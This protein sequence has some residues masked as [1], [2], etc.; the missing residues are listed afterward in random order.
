MNA[1]TSP[2]Q[3]SAAIAPLI[4]VIIPTFNSSKTLEN[5]LKSI[6]NQTYK[7]TELII[8]DAFSKDNTQQIAE[9]FKT[10]VFLLVA[11]R[12]TARNFGAKQAMGRFLFFV[13]SDMELAT[14]VIEEC[15][16]I[17]AKKNVDAAIIPEETVGTSFLAKC[18]K[19]EKR[20]RWREVF[21]EAPRFLKKEVFEF[22][23]GYNEDL[24]IGEDFELAQRLRN[25]GFSTERCKAIIKHH[26]EN[27]SLKRLTAKL[28]YYGKTLPIYARKEPLLTLKTSS[29]IHFV[30]NL[31]LLKQQPIYFAGLCSLKLV[32]YAA[33]LL[34]FFTHVFSSINS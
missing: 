25:A 18:K 4:S 19:L 17:C 6:Q 16:S 3:N 5:C 12:S 8:V 22:V 34:G 30:K 33:Y 11:E 20:M 14:S 24:V 9:G 32:E 13:D 21:F 7:N 15:V 2:R 26:E 27:V 31:S 10:K 23:G 28:Y 29:P 1:T